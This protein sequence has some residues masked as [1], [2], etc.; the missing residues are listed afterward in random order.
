MS[1]KRTRWGTLTLVENPPVPEGVEDP[2]E[3]AVS[4]KVPRLINLHGNVS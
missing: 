2:V 3:G 4:D 1:K